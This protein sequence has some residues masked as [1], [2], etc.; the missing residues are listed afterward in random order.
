[1]ARIQSAG[2]HAA[3]P[4]RKYVWPQILFIMRYP[5]L[6]APNIIKESELDGRT[7]GVAEGGRTWAWAFTQYRLDSFI[8]FVC[9]FS[10]FSCVSLSLSLSLSLSFYFVLF[11]PRSPFLHRIASLNLPA[12]IAGAKTFIYGNLTRNSIRGAHTLRL[13]RGI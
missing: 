5:S 11:H 6:I 4:R 2:R 9:D 13:V 10:L 12:S 8:S 3:P 1:M 7:C